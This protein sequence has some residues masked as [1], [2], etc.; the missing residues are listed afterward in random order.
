M[1]QHVQDET[2]DPETNKGTMQAGYA[3]LDSGQRAAFAHAFAHAQHACLSADGWTCDPSE[4]TRCDITHSNTEDPDDISPDD[5][6][7]DIQVASKQAE[8]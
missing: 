1:Y 3:W 5:D 4:R 7:S 2:F 8:A 6:K